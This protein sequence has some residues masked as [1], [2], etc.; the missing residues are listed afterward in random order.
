MSITRAAVH[1]STFGIGGTFLSI[2]CD[3]LSLTETSDAIVLRESAE[4]ILNTCIYYV[5]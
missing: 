2:G 5:V 4:N 3:K 1:H